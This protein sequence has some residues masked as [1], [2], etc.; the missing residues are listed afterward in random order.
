MVSNNDFIHVSIGQLHKTIPIKRKELIRKTM[1]LA[2]W[3]P[4]EIR[5][6]ISKGLSNCRYVGYPNSKRFT[7]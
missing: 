2:F 7:P 3:V 4:Y 6:V 1:L 5:E